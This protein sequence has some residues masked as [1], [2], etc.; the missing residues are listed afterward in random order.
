MATNDAMRSFWDTAAPPDWSTE[1][2]GDEWERLQAWYSRG[3]G[4]G[5]MNLDRFATF[6][7]DLRPDALKRYRLYVDVAARGYSLTE[8]T[9]AIVPLSLH[10]YCIVRY[11]EGIVYELNAGRRM[12][13][14]KAEASDIFALAWLHT[15]PPG[16]NMAAREAENYMSLWAPEWDPEDRATGLAWDPGWVVDSTAFECGIDFSRPHD[17][18]VS[19]VELELIERWHRTVEGQVPPYVRHSA[20]FYPLQ[21]LSY[22]ARFEQTMR[23]HLPRQFIALCRV[24]LAA[25]WQQDKALR[26]ALHMARYFRVPRDQVIQ[27]LATEQIYRG[28]IGMDAAFEAAESIL[29]H[30]EADAGRQ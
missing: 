5:N 24:Q 14:T 9:R 4:L 28:D 16:M 7:Y 18:S 25:A 6:M 29:D 8:P 27:I 1:F 26:R 17:N 11:P 30:W 3:H 2:K 10:Y 23:G 22:R 13:M 12:G 20:K 19:P 21:L 15:G